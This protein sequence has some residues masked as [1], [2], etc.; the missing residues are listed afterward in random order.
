[1]GE[2][3]VVFV[4]C[5]RGVQRVAYTDAVEGTSTTTA[6]IAVVGAGSWGTALALHCARRGFP[7][8]LWSRNPEHAGAM[9][10]QRRNPTYLSEFEFPAHLQ[11]TGELGEAV[12]GAQL[13]IC[14]IPSHGMR[15]VVRSLAPSLVDGPPPLVLIASKGVEVD[16]MATMDAVLREELPEPLRDR[17][18]ALGGPSFAAEVA[19]GLPTTVVVA[20]RQA[21]VREAIQ[22]MISDHAVR[23]YETEDVLGVELGG[24]FKN[25]I[26]IAAGIGDGAGLG[27][28][29]RAGLI[30]RGLAEI[31]RL[32]VAVGAH[33]AT[34]SGLAG[35]GDLVL[36]C[37]GGLSR[38][39][40]VGMAL[41]RGQSLDE[42]LAEMGMVAEGVLNTK[43]AHRL[44]QREGVDMPIVAVMYAILYEGLAV[45]EAVDA[46]MGR[47]LKAERG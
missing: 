36:T 12:R 24:A 10:E 20:A 22:R 13:V 7:V 41:G 35:M 45:P 32:A 31:S 30:T 4:S 40:R 15:A 38:N 8:R 42:I 18:A 11:A 5:F 2:R 17:V 43:S 29:A 27:Q 23:A 28:N 21:A 16:T 19:Q 6:P 33:P 25:V 34:L 44:A 26:A 37:T 39:R 9:Q 47:R 46:L 3:G 14:A 1:M